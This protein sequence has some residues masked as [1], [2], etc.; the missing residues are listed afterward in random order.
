MELVCQSASFCGIIHIIIVSERND[1]EMA[2]DKRNLKVLVT[3]GSEGVGL[4]VT[5]ALLHKGHTV[6][7][8]A[9][10]ADG[11]LAIRRAGALPV[12]PDL[13]RAGEVLSALRMADADIVVH[14]APQIFGGV[15][16]SDFDYES[17]LGWLVD[18]AN[19]VVEAAGKN[20]VDKII[21]ISFGYL[22]DGHHGDASTEDTH[23]VHDNAYDAMLQAESAVLDGGVDGYVVRAGYIYGSNSG[24]TSNLIDTLKES[25]AVFD[26]TKP[27]S[28]V[29]ESDLADAIVALAEAESDGDSLAEIVNVAGDE[30][31]TPNHFAI[32]LGEVFG[33]S[34][35]K[36]AT[37]NFMSV[38][39]DKT[40][41]D[42]LIARE[43]VLDTTKIKEKYGW[44]PKNAT[45]ASGLDATALVLR[46]SDAST[47]ADYYDDYEDK[48][49]EA[50]LALKSGQALQLSAEVKEE[51]PVKEKAV[52]EKKAPA[53]AAAPVLAGPTPS[54]E[55]EAKMEARRLKALERKRKRAEKKGG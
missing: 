52:A 30:A 44:T 32:A 35:I 13:T 41:R 11:A 12:Y 16:Q 34:G 29:Y 38:F 2:D 25:Q 40:F 45:I 46:M 33:Y 15:P 6:V 19:A 14:A 9:T 43:V 23:L 8:T 47:T 18:S 24:G 3:G 22:Y 37:P 1:R 55:G 27:A 48:A 50:L 36:F 10:D 5:K 51:E 4:A 53:K 20:E 26:G 54:S 31:E 39:K 28:W 21:S 7:A 49:G 42:N 17:H